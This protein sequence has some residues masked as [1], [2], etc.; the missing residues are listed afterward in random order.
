MPHTHNLRAT[1]SGQAI[2]SQESMENYSCL[3]SSQ[4]LQ[5]RSSRAMHPQSTFINLFLAHTAFCHH[6]IT[7]PCSSCASWINYGALIHVTPFIELV[8]NCPG[9]LFADFD[10]GTAAH[11]CH[12]WLP[13]LPCHS[14]QSVGPY[15]QAPRLYPPARSC[16]LDLHAPSGSTSCLSASLF[17]FFQGDNL[18]AV[19]CRSYSTLVH[20]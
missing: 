2:I 7:M 11:Q 6:A 18:G 12:S 17:V 1:I 20:G 3:A 13:Q 15:C 5:R 4:C 10:L 9:L 16:A 19:S 14:C 8:Q